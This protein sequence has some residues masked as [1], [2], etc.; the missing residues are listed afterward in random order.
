[1]PLISQSGQEER[2]EKNS[3][4]EVTHKRMRLPLEH[5]SYFELFSSKVNTIF[6]EYVQVFGEGKD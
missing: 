1:M 3:V 5:G 2:S 4:I 6:M